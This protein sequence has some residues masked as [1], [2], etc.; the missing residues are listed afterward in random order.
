[1]LFVAVRGLQERTEERVYDVGPGD[2]AWLHE[3]RE[4]GRA[5]VRLAYNGG[6]QRHADGM[7]RGVTCWCDGHDCGGAMSHEPRCWL[8]QERVNALALKHG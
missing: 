2:D 5:R 8:P 6:L 4:L 7:G 3:T 1:M